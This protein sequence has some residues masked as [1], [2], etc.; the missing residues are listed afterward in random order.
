MSRINRNHRTTAFLG[1]VLD[2]GFQTGEGPAMHPAPGSGAPFGLH[3][4]ADVFEVFQDNRCTHIGSR[5]DLLAQDVIGVLAKARSVPFDFTQVPLGTFRAFLLQRA[6]QLEVAAAGSLPAL[7][8]QKAIV[9]RNC[10]A[11]NPQIDAY[12]L[13]SWLNLACRDADNDVQPPRAI[14]FDQISGSDRVARRFPSCLRTG[15]PRP[16][17]TP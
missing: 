8:A 13:V 14:A 17:T 2:F 6:N 3:S 10:R 9:G 4:V 16:M 15:S 5:Y 12:H 1:L 11:G 7:L